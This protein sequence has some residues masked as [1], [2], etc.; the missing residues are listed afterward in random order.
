M[1]LYGQRKHPHIENKP[2][3]K[4]RTAPTYYVRRFRLTMLKMSR[5]RMLTLF[6][7]TRFWILWVPLVLQFN[8]I[9]HFAN[10][11]VELCTL[12]C[13]RPS[14]GAIVTM[15]VHV[16]MYTHIRIQTSRFLNCRTPK[17]ETNPFLIRGQ[18]F[19]YDAKEKL[20]IKQKTN[21]VSLGLK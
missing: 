17:F 13:N 14:V 4:T 16:S 2:D 7:F 15:C 20:L 10:V 19:P 8:L 1:R 5:E 3:A 11:Y 9:C 18:I 12:I 21:Y 6:R